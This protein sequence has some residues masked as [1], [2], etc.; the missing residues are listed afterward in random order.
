MAK[1]VPPF[2]A[3]TVHIHKYYRRA[4][5]ITEKTQASLRATVS[6]YEHTF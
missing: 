2:A 3:T 1:T 6:R 4:K 5:T